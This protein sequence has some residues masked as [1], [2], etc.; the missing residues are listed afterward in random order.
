M[1]AD[2]TLM[3]AG[4][5]AAK[6]DVSV[7]TVHRMC[8]ARKWPHSKIGRLYRFTDEHY[9]II[10]ATPAAPLKPRTQRKNIE[11]LLRSA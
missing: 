7:E 1:D 10:T 2:E 5:L 4:D 6:L 9:Q 3:S 11:R 8:R